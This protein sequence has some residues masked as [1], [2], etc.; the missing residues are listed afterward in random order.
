[1]PVLVE[2][3]GRPGRE[4]ISRDWS[5][6]SLSPGILLVLAVASELITAGGT[7]ID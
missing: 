6:E 4:D 7:A 1:M 2:S 5:R 3:F